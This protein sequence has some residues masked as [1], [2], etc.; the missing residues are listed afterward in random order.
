MQDHHFLV[1]RPLSPVP[2]P[3]SRVYPADRILARPRPGSGPKPSTHNGGRCFYALTRGLG[4]SAARSVMPPR[5]TFRLF[6][7]GVKTGAALSRALLI[8][9]RHRLYT[10]SALKACGCVGVSESRCVCGCGVEKRVW[11]E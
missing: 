6:P 9:S 7:R 2:S 1:L 11:H 5:L 3:I 8:R 10:V 4:I